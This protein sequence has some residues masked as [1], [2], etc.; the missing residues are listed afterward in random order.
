MRDYHVDGLRLDA[1]H[2]I[3]DESP[4]HV[5][6]ELAERVTRCQPAGARHLGDARSTTGGRSRSGVTT[7]SGTTASHH[8]LHVLLTGEQR[9]LLRGLRLGHAARGRLQ[10]DG[11]DPRRLVVCA[12]NH[13]QVGNRATG[14]RLP[15]GR[16][17]RRGRSD[18]LLAAARRSSSWAR[19]RRAAPVPVLHRP[20]R[21][22]DRR[23]DAGGPQAGVRRRSRRSP[24]RTCPTRRTSRRSSAR[25]SPGASR[26][27]S[28]ASCSRCA[29]RCRATLEVVEADED[30]QRLRLRRGDVELVADF[31]AQQ[32]ECAADGRLARQSVPARP[33]LGR[34][35]HEL[36][37]LLGERRARRALPLRRRRIAR[38]ASR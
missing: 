32:V 2:A 14:D 37:A 25:S 21:P 30:A 20:H 34:Q 6:A 3:L 29:A 26:T 38:R 5:C 11:H 24:A 36:R 27:R 9:R 23:G 12:Q 31:R 18:A 13:D 10:G 22:G 17:A 19:S 7:R 1:V 8:E 4:Q 35:R 28:T 16:A 15:P 33:D